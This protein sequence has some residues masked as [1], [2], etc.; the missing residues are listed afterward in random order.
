VFK[1]ITAGWV[2]NVPPFIGGKSVVGFTNASDPV[3]GTVFRYE[4]T[5]DTDNSADPL[6]ALGEGPYSVNYNRPGDHYV[7]LHAVNT[8]AEAVGQS[9]ESTYSSLI[10]IPVLPLVAGFKA[11]PDAACFPQNIVVTEN[12]STGDDMDWRVID[13]NGRVAATSAA[14]LPEFLISTPGKYTI[15]LKTSNSLTGQE[16]F[17]PSKEVTIYDNPVASFDLRPLL[18]YVPDTELTTFNFSTGAPEYLWDFGD[19]GSSTEKEPKYTYKVEGKY[20]VT[21]IAINDH[22]DGAV[23]MDTLKRQVTARQ[24]GVTKVPNAFTPSPNGPNGG[25]AGNNTFNDVFLPIV[26]GAEE[27]NMQIFD[28]WG[29][30]IFETNNSTVGWDGYDKHGRLLPAGVYV[31]KLTLRL[32][33][34]QRSTQIGDITM[35]R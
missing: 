30:L 3:D 33:D 26:K 29:N 21:L 24:G 34:G 7:S 19:G 2:A 22:G 5:F 32:S 17:A 8:L 25:I 14:P 23:C 28:R 15:T 27:F 35:I 20:D 16:A 10:T 12:T 13:S 6:T 31:Y 1:K 4:W 18:V 9:C 11:E